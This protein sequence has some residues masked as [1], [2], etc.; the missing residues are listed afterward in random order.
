MRWLAIFLSGLFTLSSN[1]QT[2]G[3][4][5]RRD[6]KG[7]IAASCFTSQ[8]A[9]QINEM[10]T[11]DQI[12][13]YC[14]CYAEELILPNTTIQ[15]FNQAIREL[16]K[17]NTDGMLKVFLQGRNPYSIGNVCSARAFQFRKSR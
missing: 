2:L 11:D 5:E 15:D 4:K 16:N 14:A 8:R 6:L 1:A 13:Y 3:E 12:R 7:S 17:S 9:A 10:A